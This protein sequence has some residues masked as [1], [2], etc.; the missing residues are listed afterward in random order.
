MPR[1][2]GAILPQNFVYVITITGAG[3]LR[4][5]C[6]GNSKIYK[7]PLFRSALAPRGARPARVFPPQADWGAGV[8]AYQLDFLRQRVKTP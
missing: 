4:N 6:R 7:G 5:I 3:R 2:E 8:A 1:R